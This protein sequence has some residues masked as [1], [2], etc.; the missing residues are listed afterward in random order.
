MFNFPNGIL[1][2]SDNCAKLCQGFF[3]G[4]LYLVRGFVFFLEAEEIFRKLKIFVGNGYIV[5]FFIAKWIKCLSKGNE[6]FVKVETNPI[7]IFY[8]I[9]KNK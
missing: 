3:R 9:I 2:N 8:G 1:L 6:Q 4:T 7:L 5:C